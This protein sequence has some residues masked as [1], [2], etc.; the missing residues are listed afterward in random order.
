M[1]LLGDM[2]IDDE[3]YI[4]ADS[5]QIRQ[6]FTNLL[7]NAIE[8]VQSIDNNGVIHIYSYRSK[9]R[10]F[11]IFKDNG[12]GFPSEIDRSR[13]SEPYVTHKEKGTGLGLAI[14]KKILEDHNGSLYMGLPEFLHK[15][16]DKDGIAE[17]IVSDEG[18]CV[19]A[20]FPIKFIKSEHKPNNEEFAA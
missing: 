3:I 19:V 13:L 10:I 6:V 16:L 12:P 8:A 20:S 1:P 18:A 15:A 14:V 17:H 2:A 11:I 7:Q 4:H 9:Q 5:Q